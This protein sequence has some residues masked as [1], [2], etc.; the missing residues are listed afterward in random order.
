MAA[1]ITDQLRISNCKNFVS[2]ITSPS[3]SYYTFVGLTNPSSY[4]QTWDENPPSPRDCFNDENHTWD[5]IVALKKIN[6]DDVRQVVRKIEWSSGIVYDMYRHNISRDSESL[7]SETISLYSSNY[8]VMTSEYKVY[9][10]LNNGYSPETPEGKPSLDEP[11]FTDL[12]PRAAG[13]SGDGY[14]WKYLYTIEPNDIIKFDSINFMPVP[15]NWETNSKY[16]SIRN[17]A[18]TSG[19]LKISRI[20]NRGTNVGPANRTYTG[21]KIV[22]DGIGAEATIVI[23]S[24][25]RVE[26]IT[27]SKGGSGYTYAK[28]DLTTS[29]FP[30]SDISPIFDVIIPPQNGHGYDIYRELGASNALIYSRIE[31][32]FQNPDFV[33]GTKIARVGMV[34]NPKSYQSNEILTIPKAS[35]VGA[36]K[37]KG[38]NSEDDYKITSFSENQIIQQTVGAGLTAYGI[39]LAYDKITGVLKYRQDRTLFGYTFSLTDSLNPSLPKQLLSFTS[40]PSTGGSLIISGGSLN[41][42]IDNNFNGDSVTI[43][44]RNYYFGQE[45]VDG[46]SNPEVQKYSGNIL[47][48]DNRPSITRSTNQ[49]EDIKIVLQF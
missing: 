25:R 14:V 16:F 3:N 32:D 41:L 7:P 21:V 27:I 4:S 28:V 19:Q 46:I 22:G 42:E 40:S 47:Y 20:L 2:N 38:I 17:N 39:V 11:T 36:L 31:N 35:A 6:N 30:T 23:N 44:N 43:N 1:I 13:N 26:S 9:I 10:C 29:G 5:T 18:S 33:V 8:Y 45:F 37:L 34:E 49:K 15:R 12:E 24:Q 48:V